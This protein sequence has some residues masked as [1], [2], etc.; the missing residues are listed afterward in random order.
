VQV[1]APQGDGSKVDLDTE[2]QIVPTEK[3]A[4]G[5]KELMGSSE[6]ITSLLSHV[7]VTVPANTAILR[8]TYEAATPAAAQLGSQSFAQ[9][10]INYRQ[11]VAQTALNNMISSLNDDLTRVQAAIKATV[12]VRY[13][14]G[15][16][17]YASSSRTSTC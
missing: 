11:S 14:P 1:L 2:A 5:A 7:T 10:Y 8:I 6:D 16:P 17:Q 4:T 15:T 9:A 3:V 13:T 12:A